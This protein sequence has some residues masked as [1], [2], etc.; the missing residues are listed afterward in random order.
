MCDGDK[1]EAGLPHSPGP[2]ETEAQTIG[3]VSTT[4]S[5]SPS[6]PLPVTSLDPDDECFSAS[7]S[8]YQDVLEKPSQALNK[9]TSSSSSVVLVSSTLSEDDKEYLSRKQEAAEQIIPAIV[10]EDDDHVLVSE[11]SK[12]VEEIAI[13]EGN[14]YACVASTCRLVG[15]R[16]VEKIL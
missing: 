12:C 6:Q 1:P 9:T 2:E 13:A 15:Y 7:G 8:T 10:V 5:I 3:N 14:V 11:P 16:G 4:M